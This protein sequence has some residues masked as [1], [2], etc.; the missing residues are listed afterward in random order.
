MGV[1]YVLAWLT[2]F[3]LAQAILI[4]SYNLELLLFARYFNLDEQEPLGSLGKACKQ[5]NSVL[6]IH[7]AQDKKQV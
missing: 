1:N 7:W 3:E 4:I 5:G 2:N 6:F